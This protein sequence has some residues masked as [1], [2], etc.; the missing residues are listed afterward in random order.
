MFGSKCA[1]ITAY[2]TLSSRKTRREITIATRTWKKPSLRWRS[3]SLLLWLRWHVYLYMQFSLVC[4]SDRWDAGVCLLWNAVEQIE[5]IVLDRGV[6]DSFMGLVR[7]NRS[8][9]PIKSL[10]CLEDS[11]SSRW[12][13]GRA[14]DRRWRSSRQ[15][16]MPSK[17]SE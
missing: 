13:G 17:G 1:R 6:S 10:I 5:H 4:H 8:S 15:S 11:C 2:T 9:E 12:E 16:S 14:F 7:I 3:V